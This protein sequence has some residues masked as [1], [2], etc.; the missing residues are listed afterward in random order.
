[1][2]SKPHS[3]LEPKLTTNG[4]HPEHERQI[5]ERLA[6]AFRGYSYREIAQHTGYHHETVRRYL[7]GISRIPAEFLAQA[8]INFSWIDANLILGTTSPAMQSVLRG[9]STQDLIGEL[10]RR[11]ELIENNTV[12]RILLTA[13][14]E[15]ESEADR[16]TDEDI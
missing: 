13:D 1:M 12:S 16:L 3:E 10:G 14:K 9:L 5:V 15:P 4:S 11:I 7:S 6:R 2:T 8:C